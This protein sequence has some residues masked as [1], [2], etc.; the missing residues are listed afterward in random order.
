MTSLYVQA[1][2]L[3]F[4]DLRS[5]MMQT[6]TSLPRSRQSRK[7]TKPM[8]RNLSHGLQMQVRRTVKLRL[9]T[10]NQGKTYDQKATLSTERSLLRSFYWKISMNRKLLFSLLI[11]LSKKSCIKWD[12]QRSCSESRFTLV[13]INRLRTILT[14]LQFW[15]FWEVETWGR[16]FGVEFNEKIKFSAQ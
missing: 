11:V 16:S 13:I 3:C 6:I 9:E 5:R 15:K 8:T 12:Q 1:L 7:K 10:I 2:W 14:N 4:R